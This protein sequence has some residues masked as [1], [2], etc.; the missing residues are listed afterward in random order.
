MSQDSEDDLAGL[1]IPGGFPE[2]IYWHDDGYAAVDVELEGN[3]PQQLNP[4]GFNSYLPQPSSSTRQ[5]APE[6]RPKHFNTP[7]PFFSLKKQPPQSKSRSD[8]KDAQ[9]SAAPNE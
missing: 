2:D 1:R 7:W 8:A 4:S 9:V 3:M 5:P 6:S